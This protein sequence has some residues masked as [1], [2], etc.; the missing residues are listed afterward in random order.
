[1]RKLLVLVV[2]VLSALTIFAEEAY[3]PEW[4]I[5][6]VEGGQRGG[7]LYLATTSGPKTLNTYWAQ[8][9]SSSII[10]NQGDVSLLSNDFYGQ[11][12]QPSLAK[13]WGVERTEDGGTLYWFVMR[14]G[15]RWSDGHPLT[16]D[17]VVFTW[18]KIIV[19]DL[20]A[21]GNDVYMDAEGNLPELTVEGNKIMFK[22]PTVFRF[23][24]QTVGGFAIMPKHVLEDKVTDA[25]T[26]QSTWTV[27][28][29]DQL[30]VG[31]PFK[32]TE[33]TEG[34]RVVLERNPYYFEKTK[35]GVQLPYLD[36]IVF[37]IVTDSNVARLRFE[38]GET[39]MHGPA[40][41]DFPAL[42]AQA[43][44]KG[45]N[46]IVGPAT[47][48]SNFVAFNFNAADP[49]HREWF[50]NDNFRKAIAYA[51][52]KQTI[53]DTLYNGL[54][55]PC[56][57]PRT[58]SSA[59][60]NP[61]IEELGFRHS[62]VT[63]QRLLR[64]AGFSLNEK[65]ELVDWDGNVVE[66]ELN[67]NGENVVRNEI[68]VILVDSL[69]KLGIKVNYRPLQFNAVVQKLYSANL[70][71]III[72]LVGGDDPGW[73]TNVWL[74][75]GGLH[76]WNWSPEVM[77]W[78]DPDEYW[79]HP[80]EQRIDE[81]LRVSRSILDKDELQKLWDEWQMLIAENQ[82][83]V[84]T[85]SQNYLNMHKNTLHLYPVEKYGTINPYGYSYSPG[86][87]KIEY[88]WKE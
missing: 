21:D 12:T 38:A 13:D 32:V 53:I 66:F 63:A 54:A 1:M 69:A 15:V 67:T 77:D 84:Y 41:K 34:V 44:K 85:I 59:F 65:G 4:L 33:Y 20:T 64:E 52:D 27:E 46:V 31:G 76:F 86:M 10:I 78:V 83:L 70:D 30:V 22:Y 81:I 24:F 39:D 55:V 28:Q 19:P 48:G 75:D 74:L 50:R 60:Y 51:F 57:G 88:A 9:T 56:Y 79:V 17:D 45:W 26:F 18:E 37:E 82:I 25:E 80:A 29:I 14:E 2:V 3:N 6:D 68:A 73:G 23:G 43:D 16:I 8:E 71:A 42:R 7:T 5:A 36:R 40:A 72:G 35:D 11:P 62:L 58:N 61:K 47:A 87:W 49:V